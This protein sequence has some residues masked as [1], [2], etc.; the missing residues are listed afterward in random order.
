MSNIQRTLNLTKKLQIGNVSKSNLY[1][2][3]K[4]WPWLLKETFYF[5]QLIEFIFPVNAQG[6]YIM[7]SARHKVKMEDRG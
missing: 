3:S 5:F 2:L 7:A 1:L 4:R 6:R